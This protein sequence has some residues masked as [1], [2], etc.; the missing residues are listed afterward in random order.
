MMTVADGAGAL[1]S[2]LAG[3]GR[4]ALIGG[5]IGA[6]A[7]TAGAAYTGG[8]TLSFLGVDRDLPADGSGNGSSFFLL[9]HE[10]QAPAP[11][12]GQ[13]LRLLG[14]D[15]GGRLGCVRLDPVFLSVATDATH[16]PF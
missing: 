9:Q 6:G 5:L 12:P 2:G 14:G 15:D 10:C 11:L 1:I 8:R 16:F 4:G 13:A 3:G 7:G